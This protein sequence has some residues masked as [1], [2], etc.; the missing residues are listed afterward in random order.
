MADVISG[1]V[2][3]ALPAHMMRVRCSAVSN[4]GVVQSS[5]SDSGSTSSISDAESYQAAAFTDSLP[6]DPY[7]FSDRSRKYRYS[8]LQDSRRNSDK[9]VPLFSQ[10]LLYNFHTNGECYTLQPP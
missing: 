2:S 9:S 7:Y 5:Y 1:A 8:Q 6:H 3:F 4:I 10:G